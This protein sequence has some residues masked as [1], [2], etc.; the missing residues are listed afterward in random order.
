MYDLCAQRSLYA[1]VVA[2]D[3]LAK[4]TLVPES[5]GLHSLNYAMGHS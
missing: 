5:L 2:T 3:E 4:R 1:V